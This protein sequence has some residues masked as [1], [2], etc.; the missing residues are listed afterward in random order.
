MYTQE[1]F[2]DRKELTTYA[3]EK[4]DLKL[5]GRMSMDDLIDTLN[6]HYQGLEDKSQLK[7]V[8]LNDST[9]AM[10]QVESDSHK[11]TNRELRLEKESE[12]KSLV[13]K[14][15]GNKVVGQALKVLRQRR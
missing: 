8:D 10:P 15:T 14:V 6:E 1:K 7:D 2:E 13:A 4:Y 11:K 9:S 5:D 3:R 12:R